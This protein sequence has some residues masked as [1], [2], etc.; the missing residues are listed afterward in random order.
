MEWWSIGV[1]AGMI[2]EINAMESWNDGF[3]IGR[4]CSF[5]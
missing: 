2:E 4:R 5:A 1:M 3:L